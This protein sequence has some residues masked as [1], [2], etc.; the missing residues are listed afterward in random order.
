MVVSRSLIGESNHPMVLTYWQKEWQINGSPLQR[1]DIYGFSKA[2][3]TFATKEDLE[4]ALFA[5]KEIL[6]N[7]FEKV[8]K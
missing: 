8:G 7:Y 2:S 3:A 1:L 5:S 6:M 4:G